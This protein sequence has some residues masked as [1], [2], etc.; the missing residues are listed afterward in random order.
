MNHSEE[1]LL[2]AKATRKKLLVIEFA[3][4]TFLIVVSGSLL[5][6]DSNRLWMYMFWTLAELLIT[7]VTLCA[8]HKIH[9]NTKVLEN[10]GIHK[11]SL[12]MKLYLALWILSILISFVAII[13]IIQTYSYS[14]YE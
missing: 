12:V 14:Y 8:M 2:W 6:L 9:L 3:V 13:I 5:C 4:Y 10:M 11:S 1:L 7:A